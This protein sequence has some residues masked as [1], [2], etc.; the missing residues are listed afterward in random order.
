M[1]NAKNEV[2]SEPK[3]V[4]E[5]LRDMKNLVS[6]MMDLAYFAY[7]N[8][9]KELS[10]FV[11][12]MEQEVDRLNYLLIM[13][14]SLAVRDKEDAVGVST[15]IK[16]GSALNDIANAAADIAN[17]VRIG[18]RVHPAVREAFQKA[19]E[20]VES[21]KVPPR[22]ILIGKS[23]AFLEEMGIYI[24]VIAVRRGKKWI[25]DPDRQEKFKEYDELIVRGAREI[26]DDFKEVVKKHGG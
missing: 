7:L 11:M 1:S 21:V 16:I 13:N 15:I 20:Q 23:I 12:K 10:D 3:S 2:E 19:E 6:L 14:S 25:L 24:D 18:I 17:L 22:S 8:D 5:I 4:R 9:N 26:I